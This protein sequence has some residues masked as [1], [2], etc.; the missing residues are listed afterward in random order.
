MVDST[1]NL[2]EMQTLNYLNIF[3]VPSINA[4]KKLYY[5][6]KKYIVEKSNMENETVSLV[7]V[8]KQLIKSPMLRKSLK[9]MNNELK[10]FNK[11][12]IETLKKSYHES[13]SVV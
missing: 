3:K 12:T 1:T 11:I 6:S 5:K 2:T 10:I 13:I 8:T 4:L 9:R 7:R